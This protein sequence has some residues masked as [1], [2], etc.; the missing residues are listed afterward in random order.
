MQWFATLRWSVALLGLAA[1][2]TAEAAA[3]VF[4]PTFVD[5]QRHVEKPD[6]SALGGLRFLTSD[7]YPPFNFT[8]PDGTL[9]GFNV[10]LARAV[11]GVLNVSCSIQVR[12]FDGLVPALQAR[13]GDAVVASLA[14]TEAMRRQ[15]DFSLTTMKTPAR[16]A[17]R[18]GASFATIEPDSVASAVIGV[19]EGTAHEAYLR[20]FFPH[21][22][23]HLYPDPGS[24]RLAL[25]TGAVDLIFAD[26]IATALWLD[27]LSADHCCR[28]AGGA[29]TESR[30][31]GDGTGIAVRKGDIVL[32]QAFDYALEHL[33]ADG[34]LADLTL[35]Y[36]PAGLY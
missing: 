24:L 20:A 25:K 36:F 7:D 4:V 27:G 11:C 9:T 6:L 30:Y 1:G 21:A 34:T 33:A 26:G 12:G 35:K 17:T 3:T 16:F 13:S 22:V 31:F 19:Q 10:D 23:L 29:F 18:T 8:T 32:R 5:P 15:V 2:P 28:F 14:M